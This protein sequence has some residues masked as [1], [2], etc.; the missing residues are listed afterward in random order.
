MYWWVHF[1]K[2]PIFHFNIYALLKRCL[3]YM[4]MIFQRRIV[5]HIK[6]EIGKRVLIL[7]HGKSKELQR[8]EINNT[9]QIETS[10]SQRLKSLMKYIA[11]KSLKEMLV[12]GGK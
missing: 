4:S 8:Q 10:K 11:M 1:L 9:G 3:A 6:I 2:V 7:C 12:Y 5:A